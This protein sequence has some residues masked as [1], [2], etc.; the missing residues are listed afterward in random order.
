MDLSGVYYT[1][2][3]VFGIGL[4]IFIHELGH[5]L[6]AKWADVKVEAFSLGFGPALIAKTVGETEYKLCLIPLGGYV[7]MAG[8]LP[9]EAPNPDSVGDAREFTS[10]S[11]G[12]R[13]AIIGAGPAM[14]LLFALV[15]FP[16]IFSIGVTMHAPIVGEVTPGQPA[17]VA[18]LEYGDRVERINDR[19]IYRFE[20]IRF[21][22]ALGDDALDVEYLR[23]GEPHTTRVIPA[24]DDK[25]GFQRV[26]LGLAL[27][28][29]RLRVLP[30]DGLIDRPYD[31]ISVDGRSVGSYYEDAEFRFGL[32]RKETDIV[33]VVDKDGTPTTITIPPQMKTAKEPFLGI[34]F[35]G[36]STIAAVRTADG[37]PKLPPLAAKDRI[38]AV[39]GVEVRT[40]TD[41]RERVLAA[42]AGPVTLS[43][44]QAKNPDGRPTEVVVERFADPA[45]REAALEDLHFEA[46]TIVSPLAGFAAET[47]G[48]RDGDEITHVDGEPV[49]TVEAI[50][51]RIA[52][53]NAAKNPDGWR[54]K[55]RR[56][57]REG[58]RLRPEVVEIAAAPGHN[59]MNHAVENLFEQ[60][61]LVESVQFP[62]P[63]SLVRGVKY[64]GAWAYNI[65]NSLKSIFTGR[66]AASNLG[67]ILS[68]GAVTYDRAKQGWMK[69][70][71]FL[72]ILSVNLAIVN[73]LPIPI[74]DGGQLLFLLV[75]KVKGSPV[76][77]RIQGIGQ[78]IGLVII[79]A[80]IVFVTFNDIQR[81]FG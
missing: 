30:K 71:Y 28:R 69:L 10:K 23:D 48:F 50:R 45:G 67:G 80:L 33:L 49:T 12:A 9:G 7:K 19:P 41:V 29:D 38:V 1:A 55:V 4:L 74:L 34:R 46:G 79:L 58:D 56:F 65:F 31:V 35:P 76:S 14:N 63:E 6:V 81:L 54:F 11:V 27:R 73:L 42:P 15:V 3:M 22:V 25:H 16:I 8:E 13:A 24:Y 36:T 2:V 68:I 43:V 51:K 59:R 57:H 52:A 39:Q 37:K 5:Y 53:F 61:L 21:E 77:E 75:E 32:Q 40:E 47:A 18:G 20:D 44:V 72:A 70:F 78:T 66:L 64:S 62:F 60:E 17:W 26:G